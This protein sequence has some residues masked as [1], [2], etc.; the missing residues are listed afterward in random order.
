[1]LILHEGGF[2]SQAHGELIKAIRNSLE[3]GRRV[4][5]IVPEQQTLTTEREMCDIL[6]PSAPL[7]FEVTNFTRFTNTAF[8]TLGGVG[9]SYSSN[10]QRSLVMW[11]VLDELSGVLNMTKGRMRITAATVSGALAAVRELDALGI[12]AAMLA[13]VSTAGVTDARLRAKLSDMS[14]IL[15]LYKKLMSDRY[16]D[17]GEDTAKLVE[18]LGTHPD[19]LDNTDVFVDG[20]ISFTEPQYLLLGELMRECRTT[21]SLSLPR[22]EADFFEYTE[23]KATETRLKRIASK[24]S[25][26]IKLHRPDA[27][28]PQFAPVISSI[29]RLLWRTSGVL[30]KNGLQNLK[31]NRGR[32]RIFEAQTPFEE[33]D[34]V[35]AD[36]RRRVMEGAR[37]SDFAIV[38]RDAESYVGILDNSLVA[39]NIPHYISRRRDI[40]SF[41]AIKLINTAYAIVARGFR[42][43]D[44]LTYVKCGLS[45]V[46]QTSA[47]R[48]EMYVNRW[49][50]DGR[51]F[52]DGED[53]GMNPRGYEPLRPEDA[54]RLA[55]IN[56]AKE[57]IITPLMNL[58]EAADGATTVREHAVAL[59]GFL[60]EISLEES[61]Y[62][63]AKRLLELGERELAEQNAR[64]WEKICDSLDLLV[65]VTG[66]APSDADGFIS[67]LGVVF[68]E[69][70]MATLPS[71]A[72][73]VTVGSA[74]TLRVRDVRHV[75][76]IGVNAG[77]FPANV[78]DNSYFSERDKARLFSL[79]LPI[80]PDM[81]VKSARELY[82]F[83]RAFCFG[84]DTVTLLYTRYSASMGALQ[85]SDTVERIGAITDKLV[86][87]VEIE[88]LPPEE[89]IFTPH[90]AVMLAGELGE[91]E[92]SRVREA[93]AELGMSDTVRIAEAPTENYE[94][95]LG[96][97]TLG[98][99]YGGEL[100]LSQS[101]LDSFLNCPFSYFARY[102]LGLCEDGVS[103]LSA[104][105]IGS[106]IHSVLE[107]FFKSASA[108]GGVGLVGEEDKK[109]IAEGASE[110]YITEILGGGFGQARSENAIARLCRAAMPVID[111]LCEEFANCRF[112]PAFFELRTGGRSP[113]TPDPVIYT[114]RDGT[115]IVIT[116]MVDRV[117]T[118]KSGEDVYVRVVDYKSS[119]K[120]FAPT[121]I[122]EGKNLQMFLYLKS[123]V[124]SKKPAFRER[125]G[126][127]EGGEIIPAGV[128]YTKTSLKDAVV[129]HSDDASAEAAARSLSTREG[130]ILDDEVSIG[131]TNPAFLPIGAEEE[132]AAHRFTRESW[133]ND[134]C[135]RLEGSVVRLAEGIKGGDISARPRIKGKSSPC[136]WCPYKPICRSARVMKY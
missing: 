4:Y 47:D 129:E 97:E 39:A 67:R 121:D 45:G 50:I 134:I 63:K 36:I 20:F 37:Y 57:R 95:T 40:G 106:F 52:T 81:S 12:S 24:D 111:G 79:G 116:G 60:S 77:E 21:V 18:L 104:N 10:A 46:D 94:M 29:G 15:A 87:P 3:A 123:I 1:M 90:D 75:Y 17:L 119:S 133:V 32:V 98:I 23:V 59:M 30:D 11:R 25:V 80:E 13:E 66:D 86:L 8:R 71:S 105:V 64:L 6:P 44:L 65:D 48:F 89:R 42:R 118:L 112:T 84:G 78:S 110:T 125:L 28:D 113:D 102:V 35:A 58:K 56:E 54:E 55:Q 38:A 9:G 62:G 85:P 99:I 93:L 126:V 68:D 53:W 5:L 69:A 31:E 76:L 136:N 51:R 19:F 72:D 82:S 103:E 61:L 2:T 14:S 128:I 131:A 91:E 88:A 100:Y 83:S 120:E 108:L 114:T 92:Y 43:E 74:A 27:P 127:G 41:A 101:K 117:D 16:N 49:S 7:V 115:K 33:C 96:D 109:R 26:E 135:E 107:N 70:S 34:F 73:R 22:A 122:D 130:M 124:D 132:G